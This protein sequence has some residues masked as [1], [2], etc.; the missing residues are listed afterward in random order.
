MKTSLPVFVIIVIIASG[1]GPGIVAT[2]PNAET[3]VPPEAPGPT[4]VWVTDSWNWN[5]QSRVYVIQPGY[6]AEPK[7]SA[8]WVDGKWVKT[9]NGWKYKNGYWKYK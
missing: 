7:R 5:N 4:Y 1:C 6:W 3:S 9:R 2:R 8:V